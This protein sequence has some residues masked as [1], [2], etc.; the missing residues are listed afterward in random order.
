MIR[1]LL[2]AAVVCFAAAPLAAQQ[3]ANADSRGPAAQSAA[4]APAS[5][6]GPRLAPGFHSSQPALVQHDAAPPVAAAAADRTVITIS[7]LGLVL[8]GVLLILL[9]A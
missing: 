5:A 8:L 6:P 3:P 7:T 4:P 1:P 9:L 2:L